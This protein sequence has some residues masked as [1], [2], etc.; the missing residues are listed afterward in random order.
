MAM[1]Q[2]QNDTFL[3]Q[4]ELYKYMLNMELLKLER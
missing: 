2:I 3:R 1:A 4:V